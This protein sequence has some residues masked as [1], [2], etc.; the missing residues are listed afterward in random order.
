[1][2]RDFLREVSLFTDLTGPQ[3]DRL[4]T[5]VREERVPAFHPVFHEGEPV[6]ALHLVREGTVVVFRAEADTP[7]QAL[8][9]LEAGSYFGEPGLL[10]DKSRHYASART[11]TPAILVRLGKPDLTALLTA[12][13][14][15]ELKLRSEISRRHGRHISALLSLAGHRDVRIQLGIEAV[16]EL[17]DGSRLGVVLQT[18]SLGGLALARVP[19][20]WAVGHPLRFRL[21][22]AGEPP[23]LEVG[24]S[25][26]WRE[27][28]S[29]G[30][31]FG[32]E[33]A[34]NAELIHRALQR[35]LED[36]R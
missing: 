32:P 13:P 17:E 23:L 36:R 24:G 30:I 19:A 28:D 31:A 11:A 2:L 33:A 21:G 9:H 3:L 18:L 15:L 10:N 34:G 1:M 35:F 29:V 12:Y 5:L 16:L 4:T 7:Q 25:V 6:D 26:V 22:R 14:T 8:A 20:D 27:G